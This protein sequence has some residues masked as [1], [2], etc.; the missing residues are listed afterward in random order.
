MFSIV[1]FVLVIT[2]PDLIRSDLRLDL[3]RADV[4]KGWPV[5]GRQLVVGEVLTPAIVVTWLQS[6]LLMAAVP[7]L[8]GTG[9][10][11][12]LEWG[13][14]ASGVIVLAGPL[15]V[16]TGLVQNAALLMFPSWHVIGPGHARGVEAFGQNLIASL[17]RL[18][19]L[20]VVLVPVLLV[21]AL[22]F[23]LVYP[24]AGMAAAPAI[25]LAAVVPAIVEAWLGLKALGYY[26]EAFDPSKE[27]DIAV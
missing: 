22:G 12:T 9:D 19:V 10:L 26:F 24:I 25:A 3:R 27:L 23:F 18:V 20:L 5:S 16:I 4:L 7:L 11:S 17:L 21:L 13:L 2:G 6:L 14:L 8:G 15:N 1:A